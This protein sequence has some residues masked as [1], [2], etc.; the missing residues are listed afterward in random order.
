MYPSDWHTTYSSMTG[1]SAELIMSH[2]AG[3][4]KPLSSIEVGCG[5]GHWTR[6]AI[7][8]GIADYLVVDGPWNRRKDLLVEERCFKEANLEVPLIT[9]GAFDLAICLEVAEHVAKSA[10]DVLVA[11]LVASSDVVL[12]GAAIPYQG[13]YGHINE[14]WP[15]WWRDKFIAYGY[16]PFDIVRPVFWSDVKIHYWYR[17]N[18]FIYVRRDNDAAMA[19]ATEAQREIYSRTVLFDAVH[20]EKFDEV[21]SY[22][23]IASKRLLRRLPAWVTMRVKARLK[24]R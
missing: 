9:E 16:E 22:R 18:T 17:Q 20:P 6:A 1:A 13:G 10:A 5:N 15:S 24:L 8:N 2:V 19:A 7:N 14:Q 23:S 11:S 4:F 21:A 3:I 12:F